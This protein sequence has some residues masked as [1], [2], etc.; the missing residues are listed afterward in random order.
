MAE[1][2]VAVEGKKAPDF[3]LKDQ[4][5]KTHQL[6]DFRGKFVVLY[7][8]PKDDTP[9]CTTEA[10][11]FRDHHAEIKKLG[12]VILGISPD[13]EKSH[14]KF[15]EKYNLPFTLLADPD[16]KVLEAYGAWGKKS[17]Y[18][19]VHEGV[20]RK[21]FVIGPEGRIRKIFPAVKPAEHAQQII[22]V[23]KSS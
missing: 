10:C 11:G 9:G 12:A 3:K 23:L 1:T 19:K 18:G 16:H 14:T 20:L 17:M 4:D 7:A 5:G 22:E 8:Y 6:D 13:G 15:A 21:T 2:D